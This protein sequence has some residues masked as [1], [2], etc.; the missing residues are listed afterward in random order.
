[1]SV[2]ICRAQQCSH[3]EHCDALHDLAFMC[4]P[5]STGLRPPSQREGAHWSP[6]PL[7]E[8]GEPGEELERKRPGGPCRGGV[9]NA[10]VNK[11]KPGN[12][13]IDVTGRSM[14]TFESHPLLNIWPACRGTI[15]LAVGMRGRL[16]ILLALRI[17]NDRP[18][19]QPERPET[20]NSSWL[21]LH[22]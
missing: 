14:L 10:W 20:R 12:P 7:G 4:S 6:L 2:E 1:M 8:G 5:L 9:D 17:L 22:R 19:H 18:T 3:C 13:A 16:K 15:E 11:R 21:A